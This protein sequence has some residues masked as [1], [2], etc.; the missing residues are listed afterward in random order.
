[1]AFS[2]S[3]LM[4]MSMVS[5]DWVPGAECEEGDE[6]QIPKH[7]EEGEVVVVEVGPLEALR[8]LVT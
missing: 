2:V 7:G 6:V 5:V 3:M 4:T 8:L 1:M